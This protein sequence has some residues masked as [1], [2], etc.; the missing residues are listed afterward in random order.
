MATRT[1]KRGREGSGRQLA[2][3]GHRVVVL[4]SEPI[5]GQALV[6]EIARH[7]RESVDLE[8]LFQ[9]EGRTHLACLLIDDGRP[10]CA[11]LDVSGPPQKPFLV[12]VCTILTADMATRKFAYVIGLAATL[13][14]LQA[15]AAACR[16]SVA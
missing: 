8:M 5:S 7:V 10:I 4:V 14:A 2:H 9:V 11:V 13:G 16:W 1:V 15:R 3:E 12:T 6:E